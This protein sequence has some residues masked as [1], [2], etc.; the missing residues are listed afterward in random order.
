MHAQI[1]LKYGIHIWGLAGNASINSWVNLINIEGVISNFM[2][3]A[4]VKLLSCLQ[5]KLL[6]EIS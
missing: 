2:Y 3:K 5:G 1:W 4:K 6:Q